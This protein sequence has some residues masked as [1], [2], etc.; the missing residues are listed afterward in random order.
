MLV[1]GDC[2]SATVLSQESCLSSLIFRVNHPHN[3]GGSYGILVR[4]KSDHEYK[5][6]A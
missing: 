3:A 6:I 1:G 4:K 2:F 5:Q